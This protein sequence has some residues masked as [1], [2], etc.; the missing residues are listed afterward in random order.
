MT[1]TLCPECPECLSGPPPYLTPICPRMK[2]THPKFKPFS[3]SG[4]TKEPAT[5]ELV[6]I[7]TDV[8]DRHQDF[9]TPYNKSISHLARVYPDTSRP[10]QHPFMESLPEIHDL[11]RFLAMRSAPIVLTPSSD[12]PRTSP[13]PSHARFAAT[14][15]AQLPP[16]A[17][18]R[19]R[20]A[21]ST[22]GQ[23]LFVRAR[24]GPWRGVTSA[25]LVV[26]P[27]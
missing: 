23:D 14:R 25:V 6:A 10:V 4:D 9:Q 3:T 13:F 18:R 24:E 27:F 2:G 5:A 21:C 1:G 20:S 17:R 8:T 16:K 26:A 15:R 12:S 7:S 11:D 22:P 19:A